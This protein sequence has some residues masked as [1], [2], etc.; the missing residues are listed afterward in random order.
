[1]IRC[2]YP[3]P[4]KTTCVLYTGSCGTKTIQ[5]TCKMRYDMLRQG[6]GDAKMDMVSLSQ[7]KSDGEPWI[8]ADGRTRSDE[9]VTATKVSGDGSSLFLGKVAGPLVRAKGRGRCASECT[10]VIIVLVL[11]QCWSPMDIP[12]GSLG[13]RRDTGC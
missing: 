8:D 12:Y 3:V 9:K 1:M 6:L 13:K 5:D 7:G 10:V 2:I 4:K 11:S